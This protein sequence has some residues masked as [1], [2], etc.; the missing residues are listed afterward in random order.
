MIDVKAVFALSLL[1][2]TGAKADDDITMA[3]ISD[4]HVMAPSLLKQDGAA[5]ADYV[6]HDRKMLKE[7]PALMN[8]ATE[9]IINE[10]PQYVLITGDLTK[11]GEEASHLYL[12]DQYLSR[13]RQAGIKVLVI[14]GNHDVD[15]PH[16]VE[17]NGDKTKRVYSPKK[18]GFA[19]IYS[20]YGYGQALARDTAS[21]SYMVSLAPKTRLL[22]L[23]ACEYELNDY[24][25]NT[26]ITAGRLKPA[27]LRFIKEQA[28]EAKRQGCQMLA[29]I[30]HGVV[31]HWTW[32][33]R[34]M[35]EYLVKHWRK[36]SSL[37][38]RLGIKAVFTGHFHSHDISE[39]NGVYD[40]ETGSLV[41]YPSPYRL[42][43]LSGK[44]LT[45]SSGHLTGTGISLPQ[46]ETLQQY[47]E[48]YA[49]SGIQTIV[50]GMLPKKIPADLRTE[51]CDVIAD[52][53][54]AHLA[55]DERFNA[56][57][58]AKIDKV[59]ERLKKYSW[60][61]NFIFRHIAKYLWTDLEPRDND[62]TITLR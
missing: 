37:L 9:R 60:K 53:Y 2:T 59:S 27:T 1:F 54:V 7:S 19:A 15:N 32:Q 24:E 4:V 28:K 10:H 55:G 45:I 12:R 13:M 6:L 51:A 36:V 61:Y 35:S 41:S 8:E 56:D 47:G 21:L 25:K 17:F 34:A 22:C 57:C 40:I 58:Q 50:G 16:A 18:D 23:D 33:E 29:M 20:D 26:C 44:T 42:V 11:D 38:G 39:R 43:R 31:H 46:G 3:V 62:I 48:R 14:P 52:A 5:F 49:H 30:H